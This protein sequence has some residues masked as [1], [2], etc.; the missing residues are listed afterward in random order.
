MEATPPRSLLLRINAVEAVVPLVAAEA[1]VGG[2]VRLGLLA[3]VDSSP[4]LRIPIGSRYAANV[5]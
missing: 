3:P 1:A 5:N 4:P 2:R